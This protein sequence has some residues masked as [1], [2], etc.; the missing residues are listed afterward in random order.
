MKLHI[1]KRTYISP[2][3]IDSVER[4]IP[5]LAEAAEFGRRYGSDL[6]FIPTVASTLSGS[7]DRIDKIFDGVRKAGWNISPAPYCQTA[8]QKFVAH[9]FDNRSND[10][11]DIVALMC[12]DQFPLNKTEH[13]EAVNNLGLKLLFDDKTYANGSRD[14][15]VTLGVHR[16]NSDRRII[17][18][19]V[20]TFA[21]GTNNFRTPLTIEG[22]PHPAYANFGESTS[23]LYMIN[24][25]GKVYAQLQR[26]VKASA[27][28]FS[29]P[30]FA[31]EYMTAILA[32]RQNQVSSG[33][34][35]AVRN[36]FYDSPTEEDEKTSMLKLISR[37]TDLLGKTPAR[38]PVIDAL[39][40]QDTA[41]QL[42]SVF[43]KALVDEVTG[44]MR[45][46]LATQ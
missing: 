37:H 8:G 4:S 2:K 39:S 21:G 17:H 19:M 10:N 12:L 1:G 36:P 42:Y 25:C 9:L 32:G 44:V 34:V 45:K 7:E 20:H 15:E 18:E 30:G 41:D 14:V 3:E 11:A 29:V 31:I 38:Q 13:W 40:I 46:S 16:N 22:Q 23:G 24:R 43:D 27:D 28:V 5:A 6:T 26:D 35:Y 33:Y